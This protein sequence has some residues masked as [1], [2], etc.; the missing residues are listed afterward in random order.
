[1]ASRAGSVFFSPARAAPVSRPRRSSV[2]PPVL[3]CFPLAPLCFPPFVLPWLSPPRR[4]AV[5]ARAGPAPPARLCHGTRRPETRDPRVVPAEKSS[6]AFRHRP[7]PCPGSAARSRTGKLNAPLSTP[8]Q[9]SDE[10]PSLLPPTSGSC[11]T[12]D[13]QPVGSPSRSGGVTPV[14]SPAPLT[15]RGA[16]APPEPRWAPSRGIWIPSRCHIR[17]T[18]W[19]VVERQ[20][21]ITPYG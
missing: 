16:R 6:V 11:V 13:I 4:P 3:I 17:G 1:M 10:T 21:R 18:G 5:P 7:F 19:S 14:C 15:G 8:H 12:G 9:W 20:S 2:S